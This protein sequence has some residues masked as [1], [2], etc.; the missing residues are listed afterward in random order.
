MLFKD[1]KVIEKGKC[2]LSVGKDWSSLNKLQ[3]EKEEKL[4]LGLLSSASPLGMSLSSLDVSSAL[5]QT[6]L[7]LSISSSAVAAYS[8]TAATTGISAL[9]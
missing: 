2:A 1:A 3:S 7:T 5:G 6:G 8:T 9:E 4:L